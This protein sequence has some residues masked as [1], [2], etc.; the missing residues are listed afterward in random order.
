MA[1]LATDNAVIAVAFAVLAIGGFAL[2]LIA[3]WKSV[4][5]EPKLDPEIE[6]RLLLGE[7][8]E[9]IA[10]DEDRPTP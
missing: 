10:A 8:P 4:R 5:K 2:V 6:N 9:S 3:P 7:D 1:P